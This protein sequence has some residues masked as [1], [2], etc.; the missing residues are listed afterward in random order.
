MK[1][2][3]SAILIALL[4]VLTPGCG[5]TKN[6]PAADNGAARNA[7]LPADHDKDAGDPRADDNTAKDSAD[8]DG[9]DD[10]LPAGVDEQPAAKLPDTEPKE[11]E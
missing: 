8:K 2:L 3:L 9:K 7:N 1:T 6:K 11:K 4:F 10:G 5:D